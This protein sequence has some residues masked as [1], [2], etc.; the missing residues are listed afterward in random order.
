MSR[1]Y[2][3]LVLPLLVACSSPPEPEPAEDATGEA[4]DAGATLDANPADANPASGAHYQYVID[5][6]VLPIGGTLGNACGLN[7]DQDSLDR[8]ENGLSIVLTVFADAL[9]LSSGPQAKMDEQLASGDALNLLDLQADSLDDDS[10]VRVR[11]LL[12]ADGDTPANPADNFS[13]AETFVIQGDARSD[14]VLDGAIRD[15]KLTAGPGDIELQVVGLAGEPLR[16]GLEAARI[17]AD[18]TAGGLLNGK[19]GGAVREADIDVFV[20]S[21]GAFA[22]AE[23]AGCSGAPPDCCPVDSDGAKLLSMFDADEDCVITDGEV[24]ANGIIRS[25][26]RVDADLFDP[27][28]GDYSPRTDGLKDSFTMG[29][30]FTAVSAEFPLP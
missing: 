12:G 13:G 1:Q 25:S 30:C 4:F 10:A 16:L 19:V 7:L 14:L 3:R 2:Y 8:S 15:G 5:T 27:G 22:R 17:E 6:V 29:F 26:L 11:P 20:P 28:D 24:A 18:V 23:T 21:L 9:G